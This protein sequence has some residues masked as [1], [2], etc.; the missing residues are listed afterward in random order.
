MSELLPCVRVEPP[1]GAVATVIWLHGLGADGHD[2][3][4]VVPLLRTRRVRFVFPNAPAIPV[5]INGGFVMPAWYDIRT[6]DFGDADREDPAQ[7]ERS[8][9][10]IAA[11]VE[12]E[13]AAGIAAD[14]IVL[15]GFSQGAA[16]AIHTGVRLRESIAGIVALSGYL[17]VPHRLDAERDAANRA[18]PVFVGHGLH[19]DMVPVV[20]GRTAWRE[21]Q[22]TAAPGTAC[23][24]HEYP[25]GHEVC[26]EE[27]EHV[28]AQLRAWLHA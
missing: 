6:L 19:D 10:R 22:R 3:E 2:F 11:L 4:P 7:I 14:R 21:L 17:V 20:A 27:L 18:T 16:M 26:P 8:A 12:R 5:T 9:A 25:M 28:G 13:R 24:W 23:T 15:A 1:D